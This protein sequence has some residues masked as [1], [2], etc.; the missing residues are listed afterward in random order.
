MHEFRPALSHFF[1]FDSI[2]LYYQLTQSLF[3]E[4]IIYFTWFSLKYPETFYEGVWKEFLYTNLGNDFDPDDF[5][6]M[7]MAL[8]AVSGSL[9]IPPPN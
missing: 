1:L 3:S 7:R 4:A 2:R 5:V 6:I 8:L 9:N